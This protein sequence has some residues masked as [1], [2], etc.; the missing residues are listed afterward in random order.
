[1]K[2]ILY[3]EGG[4]DSK[5]L[6]ARCREGFHKL[7]KSC[8]FTG[9]MPRI[10]ACG[11][12]TAT[13]DH[14]KTAFMRGDAEFVAMLIDSEHPLTSL[15]AAWQH[16]TEQEGWPRPADAHDEQV[17]FMTTCMETWIVA[18]R[19]AL[20][21]HYGHKLR[22]TALP[23]LQELE[24][25]EHDAIQ[26]GLEQATRECSNAYKKGK[27]SFEVLAKLS[28]DTLEQHLPSFSRARR[29]FNSRL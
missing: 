11:A 12:R 7:L 6:H 4:G 22:T 20:V 3:V 28:P 21:S 16:L 29:I 2:T 9:R 15:E 24:N 25:R 27:R 1:V 10:V 23:P 17:L 18:D 19:R 5:E 8:G 13:F 26:D 14:F